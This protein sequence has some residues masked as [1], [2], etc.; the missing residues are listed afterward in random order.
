MGHDFGVKYRTVVERDNFSLGVADSFVQWPLPI[1]VS[2][3]AGG[4]VPR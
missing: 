1:G 2:F 4:T 3:R